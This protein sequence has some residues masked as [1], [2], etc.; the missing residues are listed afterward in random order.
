[1]KTLKTPIAILIFCAM[2]GGCGFFDDA[3]E[4]ARQL[5]YYKKYARTLEDKVKSLSQIIDTLRGENTRLKSELQKYQEAHRKM[6]Q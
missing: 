6:L 2:L 3:K 1:M 5:E 4:L